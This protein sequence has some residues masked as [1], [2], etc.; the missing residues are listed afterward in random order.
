M[1]VLLNGSFGVGKATVA[2]HL[3]EK[4]DKTSIFNPEQVGLLLSRVGVP[5]HFVKSETDDFQDIPQWRR[6]TVEGV[7]LWRHVLRRNV[8]VPMTIANPE[9]F[10]EIRS[11]L[12]QID[13]D[14]RLFCLMAELQTI[15][16]R[17]NSC[18]VDLAS[19]D[20]RWISARLA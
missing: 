3:Q 14:L 5:L 18:G 13:P 17:L 8:I 9:Y 7:R 2:R 6:L 11:G 1:I 4:L 15:K 20:G 16:T 19:A 12:V 10:D